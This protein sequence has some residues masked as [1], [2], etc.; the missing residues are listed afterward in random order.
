MKW[1]LKTDGAGMMSRPGAFSEEKGFDSSN[2]IG[3][4]VITLRTAAGMMFQDRVL[5]GTKA[6]EGG[7]D[8]AL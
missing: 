7:G 4:G 5:K 3:D 2:L 8:P 6:P 1:T